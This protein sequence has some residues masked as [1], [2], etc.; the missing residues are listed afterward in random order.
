MKY[1]RYAKGGFVNLDDIGDIADKTDY[2]DVFERIDQ[3]EILMSLIQELGPLD[4]QVITLYLEDL[5]AA[6]IGDISGLSS[7]AIATKIH[8]IKFKLANSFKKGENYVR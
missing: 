4:R 1:K 5:D 6:A 3:I 7:G 2:I 8:R